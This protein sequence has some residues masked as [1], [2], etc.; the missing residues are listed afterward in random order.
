MGAAI[1]VNGKPSDDLGQDLTK[2]VTKKFIITPR[3]TGISL[4]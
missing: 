2:K 3:V 1:P 4:R